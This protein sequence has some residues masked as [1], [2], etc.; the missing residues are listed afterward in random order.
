[1][2]VLQRKINSLGGRL[3]GNWKQHVAASTKWNYQVALSTDERFVKDGAWRPA[4][5]NLL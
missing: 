3:Y 2:A 4:N 1:M 5:K